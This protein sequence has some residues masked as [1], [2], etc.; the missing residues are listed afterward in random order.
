MSSDAAGMW[1]C[2]CGR[3]KSFIPCSHPHLPPWVTNAFFRCNISLLLAAIHGTKLDIIF[4]L[5]A[6]ILFPSQG[7]NRNYS[8]GRQ[9]G[10]QPTN[11]FP[12]SFSPSQGCNHSEYRQTRQKA[13]KQA[14]KAARQQPSR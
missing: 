3:A 12:V 13:N 14:M 4:T 9:A 2:N 10:N 5:L 7:C 6:V 1:D 11:R 8:A